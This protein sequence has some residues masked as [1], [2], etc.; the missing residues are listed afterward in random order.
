MRPL[1]GRLIKTL[2]PDL[3]TVADIPT[4]GARLSPGQPICTLL[5]DDASEVAV[6]DKLRQSAEQLSQLLERR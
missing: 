3:P 1:D 5:A 2:S 4:S 6:L